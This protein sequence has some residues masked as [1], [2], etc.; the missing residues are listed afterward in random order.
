MLSSARIFK[1]VTALTPRGTIIASPGA[2]SA[3]S[4]FLRATVLIRATRIF[5]R[6]VAAVVVEVAAAEVAGGDAE[7]QKQ[8]RI[9][10]WK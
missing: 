6:M 5:L 2:I 10:R 3:G 8:K 9:S 4:V 7:P 1:R